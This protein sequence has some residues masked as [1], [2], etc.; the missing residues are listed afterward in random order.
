MT[1]CEAPSMRGPALTRPPS[2]R[3]SSSVRHASNSVGRGCAGSGGHGRCA[4]ENRANMR[5][6]DRPER[7]CNSRRVRLRRSSACSRAVNLVSRSRMRTGRSCRSRR[8][9]SRDFEHAGPAAQSVAVRGNPGGRE[10]HPDGGSVDL[11]AE[12]GEFAVYAPVSPRWA[13]APAQSGRDGLSTGPGVGR[14]PAAGD[15]SPVS[16]QDRTCRSRPW[17][18]VSGTRSGASDTPLVQR[19]SCSRWWYANPRSS[20]RVPAST[21]TRPT[22][23][24]LRTSSRMCG[25]ARRSRRGSP[26][27]ARPGWACIAPYS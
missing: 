10:D 26:R 19:R 20:C 15:E 8:D 4:A 1:A 3:P 18:R 11:V 17:G 14:G 16:G 22:S 21:S 27:T 6:R 7:T 5:R 12:A 9:P 25:A 23:A 2:P 24:R 13:L